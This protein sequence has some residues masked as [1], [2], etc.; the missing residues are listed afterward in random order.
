MTSE[1]PV[2]WCSDKEYVEDL[3]RRR[4]DPHVEELNQLITTF[5]AQHPGRFMPFIAPTFGGRN[6]RL[7]ALFQE[8]GPKTVPSNVGSGMLCIENDDPTAARH[9]AL[10]A[11][12]KIDT[13]DVVSWNAH[14]WYNPQSDAD[15]TPAEELAATRMLS[16]VLS[17][18]PNL[19]VVM[20]HG[21]AARNAW[22]RLENYTPVDTQVG[23]MVLPGRVHTRRIRAINSW[24]LSPR[25]VDP[26]TKTA[27]EVARFNREIDKSFLEATA[28]LRGPGGASWLAWDP[29]DPWFVPT[30]EPD[31]WEVPRQ[32]DRPYLPDER[33]EEPPF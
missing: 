7:L 1:G 14:P 20:L 5:R 27:E 33:V 15:R 17:L 31:P 26:A 21:H 10:L 6:A 30:Y 9:K 28:I 23:P 19:R 13:S 3:W 12:Y 2:Q 8:P 29:D 22:A 18:L 16:R 11:E 32:S 4:D 25:V 24:H